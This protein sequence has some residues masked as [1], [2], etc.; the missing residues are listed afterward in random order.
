MRTSGTRTAEGSATGCVPAWIVTGAQL[1]LV[2]REG[3]LQTGTSACFS[4]G[5]ST[6]QRP[7]AAS[8]LKLKP[9]HSMRWHH[10]AAFRSFAAQ[11]PEVPCSSL[12]FFLVTPT[13]SVKR[14]RPSKETHVSEKQEAKGKIGFPQVRPTECDGTLRSLS[15]G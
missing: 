11:V 14:I 7:A 5:T 3:N 1:R 6:V 15:S 13:S 9:C 10:G 8:Q 2:P 12:G 4:S